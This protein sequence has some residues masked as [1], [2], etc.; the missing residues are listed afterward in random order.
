VTEDGVQG[1]GVAAGRR[2]E[3]GDFGVASGDV[4]GDAQGRGHVQAPRGS[5]VQHLV[6]VRSLFVGC[7]GVRCLG[8][9]Q[10]GLL[11]DA[12]DVADGICEPEEHLA[13][14]GVRRPD[15]LAA[16]VLHRR[17]G[18]H[19]VGHH[20]I[21]EQPGFGAGRAAFDEGPTDLADGVVKGRGTVASLPHLPAERLLVELGGA[22]RVHGGNL[23]VADLPRA[24]FRPV[25]YHRDMPFLFPL[26][27]PAPI[28]SVPILPARGGGSRRPGWTGPTI[29]GS[30]HE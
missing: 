16:S 11:V 9:S 29:C 27:L 18:G 21:N 10:A 30:R 2:G 7:L 19:G 13:R 22:G 24:P 15:D 3:L 4:V 12:E 20:D 1:I 8:L 26:R 5:Q 14:G 25:F 17:Q 6:E 23:D 28:P